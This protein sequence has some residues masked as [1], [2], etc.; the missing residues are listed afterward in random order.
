ML[1]SKLSSKD[2]VGIEDGGK[3][4]KIRDLDINLDTGKINY[5]V[6]SVNQNI[7]S[8]FKNNKKINVAWENVMKIGG[9]VILVE[10]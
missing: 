7:S 6:V 1:L 5:I 8:L 2:I 4:G 9:E 10:K 3:L